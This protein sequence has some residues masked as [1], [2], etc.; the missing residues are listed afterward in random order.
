MTEFEQRL[1]DEFSKLAEQHAQE[2]KELSAPVASLGK[3]VRQLA[4]QYGQE[5]T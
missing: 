1:T 5:Q 4:G 2:Q 3:R